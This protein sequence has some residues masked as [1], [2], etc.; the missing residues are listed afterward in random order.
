VATS[1]DGGA[2]PIARVVLVGM[3]G[4]GKTAV[5]AALAARLGWTHVDLDDEVVRLDGRSV[6]RIFA[7]DG[8]PRFRALEAE[9]A[10]ALAGRA[11]LVVSTG[12]G[13]GAR[14]DALRGWGEGTLGVWLKVPPDEAVRRAAGA[15]GA[16]PLLAG[17]DPRG[18]VRRLLAAREAGYARAALH[19]DTAGRTVD[20]VTR[21]IEAAVRTRGTVPG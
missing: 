16:R 4:A 2:A 5:G 13:W 10:A 7:E 20:Q 14:D 12:G 21:H 15:P 19:V 11:R 6:A 9:S 3:M 1:A 8:E 18:T 17:P